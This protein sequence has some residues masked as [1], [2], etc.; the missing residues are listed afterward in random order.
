M[1]K[2]AITFHDKLNDIVYGTVNGS[3]NL[4][5]FILKIVVII[6]CHYIKLYNIFR[7]FSTALGK[8]MRTQKPCRS[9]KRKLINF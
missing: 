1:I 5:L 6:T 9:E 7:V 2:I 3:A 4:Y 8:I